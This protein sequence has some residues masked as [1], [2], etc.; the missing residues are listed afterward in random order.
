ML[1]SSEDRTVNIPIKIVNGHVKYYYGGDLPEILDGAI[2]ELILP[3]HSIKEPSFISMSNTELETEILPCGSII[4]VE[5]NNKVPQEKR[6]HLE[7][8]KTLISTSRCFVRVELLDP[9][10][11]LYRGTKKS[12]LMPVKCNIPCLDEKTGSLNSAYTIISEQF[13]P[14]RVS[15]TGNVFSKCY[16]KGNN[17]LWHP[18]DAI[19]ET[20]EAKF[21]EIL[22]FD[23]KVYTQKEFCNFQLSDDEK[24]VLSSF[25]PENQ[26]EVKKIKDV[27]DHDLLRCVS[28][29]H[30][31]IDK[32]VIERKK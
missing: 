8:I 14:Q 20:E 27:F 5:V 9:L 2:G 30:N 31:L 28:A 29:I 12:K 3:E 19:R 1:Y 6:L 4:M 23:D 18:L 21:E 25:G 15:H 32:G 26:I 11:L 16:Y 13:E 24:K 17:D 22:I 7:E 10:Y